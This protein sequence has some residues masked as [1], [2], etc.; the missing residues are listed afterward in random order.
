VI[1]NK[2]E[3]YMGTITIEEFGSV[4]S[5]ANTDLPIENLDTLLA[6]TK[7]AT[8]STSAESIV[9][10]E[11]TRVVTITAVEAHRVCLRTDTT[12]TKYAV[13]LA[14]RTVRFGVPPGAVL[15]YELDA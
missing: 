5:A 4:G 8:T 15:F 10:N 14:N 6:I 12:A 3:N 9:L 1:I 13:V 11:G 7:D 2:Q